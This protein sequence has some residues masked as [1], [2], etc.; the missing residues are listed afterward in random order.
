[1][2]PHRQIKECTPLYSQM[3]LCVLCGQYYTRQRRE[4]QSKYA[5]HQGG[6]NKTWSIQAKPMEPPAPKKK[7]KIPLEKGYSQMD[8]MRLQQS[9]QD[10]SGENLFI[11][12]ASLSLESLNIKKFRWPFA[13][14]WK[15]FEGRTVWGWRTCRT[16]EVYLKGNILTWEGEFLADARGAMWK[17][18]QIHSIALQK[19]VWNPLLK[20]TSLI[21]SWVH[22]N[23]HNV[24][25][26]SWW[27]WLLLTVED[28]AS[29][30]IGEDCLSLIPMAS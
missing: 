6:S 11:D 7:G 29:W 19:T 15:R 3:E 26:P 1:M 9:R 24:H 13:L 4:R 20:M 16:A 17:L 8:W 21:S 27:T 14:S 2:R 30:V 12:M 18:Y 5:D 28:K 10:L 22:N 23:K 25:Y